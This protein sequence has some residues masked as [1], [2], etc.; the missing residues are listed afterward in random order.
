MTQSYS[1]CH[2]PTN[3]A[4]DQNNCPCRNVR[5]VDEAYEQNKW[6]WSGWCEDKVDLANSMRV[7][8]KVRM[9]VQTRSRIDQDYLIQRE[10]YKEQALCLHQCI[11]SVKVYLSISGHT[12]VL[13]ANRMPLLPSA[14]ETPVYAFLPRAKNAIFSPLA[15][16]GTIV[17][18]SS[19]T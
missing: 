4:E 16:I 1:T 7:C 14:L 11:H 18:L 19:V 3:E 10:Y 13:N 15:A 12:T 6:W 2:Q 8:G 5:K 17:A 9:W